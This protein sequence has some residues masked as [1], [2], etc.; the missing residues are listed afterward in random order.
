MIAPRV[1]MD[2]VAPRSRPIRQLRGDVLAIHP[3]GTC[4]MA[5]GPDRGV[6]DH[7]CRVFRADGGV[8]EFEDNMVWRVAELLGLRQQLA[9]Q[10]ITGAQNVTLAN[11]NA[12]IFK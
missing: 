1:R 8:H 2:H 9:E 12:G 5:S 7:A 4:R 10:G 6:I 3:L 11:A